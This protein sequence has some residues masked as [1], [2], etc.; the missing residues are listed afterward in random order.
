MAAWP[1]PRRTTRT[2]EFRAR[3]RSS[4]VSGRPNADGTASSAPY[5][6]KFVTRHFTNWFAGRMIWAEMSVFSLT[7]R[8]R[9]PVPLRRPSTCCGECERPRGFSQ[10]SLQSF[11]AAVP[12]VSMRRWPRRSRS[13]SLLMSTKPMLRATSLLEGS[14]LLRCAA[15][16]LPRPAAF[17]LAQSFP[18]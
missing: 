4:N 3:P 8:R 12:A 15:R 16:R 9:S 10:E 17:P 2:W 6:E 13:R 11:A 5:V 14:Q 18:S 7:A 1:T